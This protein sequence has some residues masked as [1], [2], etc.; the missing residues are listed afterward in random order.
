MNPNNDLNSSDELTTEY[1]D[2]DSSEQ[3]TQLNKNELDLIK[4][5]AVK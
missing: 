2:S 4:F 1:L 5:K 3:K